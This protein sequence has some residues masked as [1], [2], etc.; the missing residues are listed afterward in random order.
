[1]ISVGEQTLDALKSEIQF[2]AEWYLERYPDVKM[3]GM[4]PWEH[5]LWIGNKV[6]RV[7][8]KGY[9]RSK[10]PA[11]PS[12]FVKYDLNCSTYHDDFKYPFASVEDL[13][14]KAR[15]Y[16]DACIGKCRFRIAVYT[17][18]SGQYDSIL[19]HENLMN[20]SEYFIYTDTDTSGSY[21]YKNHSMPYFD[22]EPVRRS[23]FVKTHPHALFSGHDL[24]IWLDGNMLIRGDISRLVD[25]F[26]SSGAPIGLVPHPHRD[27]VY[28]EAEACIRLK[29]DNAET[30]KAQI[31]RYREEGFE[32]RELFETGFIMFRLSHPTLPA[33]MKIWWSEIERGSFRDQLSI[34]YALHKSGANWF[35]ITDRPNS[36]RNH[37]ELALLRHGTHNPSN[38]VPA[39]LPARKRMTYADVVNSRLTAHEGRKADIVVCVHNALDWVKICMESVI[40][41]RNPLRHRIIIV[42]DGSDIR[43]AEWI[44][45]V[46]KNTPNVILIRHAEAVGYTKAANAGLR[47]SEADFV[48]LLNS[49]TIVAGKWLEK[50][51]DAAF[52][53]PGVG[54][55]GPLSSAASHQSIPDHRSTANQTAINDLPKGYS[56]ADMNS[57][58][59][60]NSPSDS[61]PL[62][63]LVHGFCFGITRQVI[64]A[65]GYMDEINFPRGYG[66]E[67]DYCFR[68][69]NAGFLL[70]IA[71]HTYV[72]HKKSQSF[73]VDDIR[74]PLMKAGNATF[75]SIHGRKRVLRAVRSMENNPHL[76]KLRDLSQKLYQF[77][78]ES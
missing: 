23:R 66:E 17:A 31:T 12:E 18:I 43:T 27:N 62:V 44:D 45:R 33:L 63:P 22:D 70:A 40:E 4:D 5:Y 38:T 46:V 34:S 56:V 36:V 1:M 69:A 71:T 21:V 8:R 20:D 73:N 65:I 59:E 16:I 28:E 55:V 72:Y 30:I 78:A 60:A 41:S 77:E 19:F 14:T 3:L 15:D 57:W 61:V 26:W 42:D 9:V 6:G 51:M 54:I 32:S 10:L 29:K 74:I 39:L 49:D 75:Q 7:P 50:L 67:S 52:S 2:D 13:V 47:K 48:V 11:H 68:A 64:N 25:D 37:P 35:S 58:C 76:I 24:A 53:T